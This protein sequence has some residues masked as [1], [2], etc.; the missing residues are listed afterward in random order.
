MNFKTHNTQTR[1]K[2]RYLSKSKISSSS[3]VNNPQIK[4]QKIKFK[5]TNRTTSSDN[6]LNKKNKN[7]KSQQ[8]LERN[9]KFSQ[10]SLKDMNINYS[11]NIIN[12][13]KVK[14][15]I[16][17]LVN[18]S[19]N[20]LEQQ[21]E[22]LNQADDLIK[23]I[24]L[25]DH[26][27]G[28]IKKTEKNEK[29]A[30]KIQ[31]YNNNLEDILSKIKQSTKDIEYS[32]K[33]KEENNNLKYRMQMLSIDKSDNYISIESELNSLKNTYSNE[34]NSMLRFLYELGFDNIS[35]ES[36]KSNDLSK[37]KIINFFEVIKNIIKELK[38]NIEEKEGQIELLKKIKNVENNNANNIDN[39]EHNKE[40]N[41]L[42]DNDINDIMAP[43]N[44]KSLDNNLEINN[45]DINNFSSIENYKNS[46][47]NTG[48]LKKI[49]ELCLNHN[50][51][52]D[53]NN[54]NNNINNIENTISQS[55]I[56]NFQRSKNLNSISDLGIKLEHNYTDS[57]FYPNV[58]E[59]IT[60]NKNYNKSDLNIKEININN[61]DKK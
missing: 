37:N 18:T 16:N 28:K 31:K 60:I 15:S 27:I 36:I 25:N 1:P 40:I 11:M 2:S 29:F 51:E 17:R 58:K 33:I 4:K 9:I 30:D 10:D 26:L 8:N 24:E 6:K 42:S 5:Y 45:K 38:L 56:D 57:Y 35:L 21:N 22:I 34:M 7:I 39:I 19:K 43:I 44:Y 23:N 55:Y 59:S 48:R 13:K 20:L 14:N 50:Y 49:E 54:I 12:E 3:T 46:I 61:G 52:I 41:N 53:S 32:N 47:N